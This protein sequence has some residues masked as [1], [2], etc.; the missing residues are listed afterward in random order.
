MSLQSEN[1]KIFEILLRNA[2]KKYP[3]IITIIILTFIRL[4]KSIRLSSRLK[5]KIERVKESIDNRNWE[6][7]TF[8]GC[9]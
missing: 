5:I 2:M 7:I 3:I 1:N 9:Q 4:I 6:F 8:K